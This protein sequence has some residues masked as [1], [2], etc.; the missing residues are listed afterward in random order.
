M[1]QDITAQERAQQATWETLEQFVRGKVQ[2]FVQ[3]LG[4]VSRRSTPVVATFRRHA[5]QE[6][7]AHRN[8]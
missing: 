7:A 6:A 1:G 5:G 4:C 8:T 2:G 3:E